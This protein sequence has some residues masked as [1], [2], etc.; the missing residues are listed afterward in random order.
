MKELYKNTAVISSTEVA[1]IVIAV[2]RNK[3][4][5]VQI[6]PAGFG[7]F[8]LL[9][10]FFNVAAVFSGTWLST[11]VTKY[12]SE[13]KSEGNTQS[14]EKVYSFSLSLTLI[15]STLIAVGSI[16]LYNPISQNFLTPD[17]AFINFAF[18]A[19]AFIG[20]SLKTLFFS[21]MQGLMQ[22]KRVAYVRVVS[23]IFEF[24]AVVA[25]VYLFDLTGFFASFLIS[26]VFGTLLFWKEIAK[27]IHGR[28][29]LPKFGGE[30]TK[31][32]INFGGTNLALGITNM[33]S[34]YLQRIVLLTFSNMSAIGILQAASSIMNYLGILNRGSVFGY[35][36][37]MSE[38]LT[39]ADRNRALN[40]YLRF[41]LLTGIPSSVIII[42]LGKEFIGILFSKSFF[43]LVDVLSVFVIAQLLISIEVGFQSII[44]GTA[45]LKLHAFVSFLTHTIWV[46]VPLFFLKYLGI[47]AIGLS[48]CGASLI[49]MT[50][51]ASYLRVKLRIEIEKRV[52]Q[53]LFIAIP[54]LALSILLCRESTL[55]R[56]MFFIVSTAGVASN[57]TRGEWSQ[58]RNVVVT[59]LAR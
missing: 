27:A 14:I 46:L 12:I 42:L 45:K 31:K 4:L 37:K 41:T 35:L 2:L 58:I 5:A 23:T 51:E 22:T 38:N 16:V 20:T 54:V 36:P 29:A 7:M 53:L 57:V 56:L 43:E 10:S 47:V 26:A 25:M 19:A 21:V 50:I 33:S 44:V 8:G 28:L 49:A 18:F 40:D 24:V 34:Q 1:L 15:C 9:S 3:Y 48:F 59:R 55:W 52:F 32:V 39:I 17:I 30:V 6:G 13:Y 11:G